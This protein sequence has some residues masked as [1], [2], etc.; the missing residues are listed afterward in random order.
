MMWLGFT[1]RRK[2]VSFVAGINQRSDDMT[3]ETAMSVTADAARLSKKDLK[4]AKDRARRAARKAAVKMNKELA[5]EVPHPVITDLVSEAG[6]KHLRHV[7][8]RV[9]ADP[10]GQIAEATAPTLTATPV[11]KANVKIAVLDLFYRTQGVQYTTAEAVAKLQQIHP[12]MNESSIR[13]WM[14]DF[15]KDGSITVAK[16]D[17]N[18]AI[19]EAG[20]PG[21]FATRG[22]IAAAAN[23]ALKTSP[24]VESV[25]PTRLAKGVK[26]AKSRNKP[27]KRKSGSPTT[28]KKPKAGNPRPKKR[29]LNKAT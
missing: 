27:S 21:K 26:N 17:G 10:A 11:N 6:K 5:K 28:V 7:Q 16:M 14:S 2:S 12:G 8:R 13:V 29:K 18:K 4:K 19:L 22:S 9:A 23:P 1:S 20:K 3:L 25:V 15:R 24:V